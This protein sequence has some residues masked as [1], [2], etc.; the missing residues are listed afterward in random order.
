MIAR[1]TCRDTI[2]FIIVGPS[3]HNTKP[4]QFKGKRL[5][6]NDTDDNFLNI[7]LFRGGATISHLRTYSGGHDQWRKQVYLGWGRGGAH[8]DYEHEA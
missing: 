8:L 2:L 5:N 4:W 1:E 6:C 3:S 7:K